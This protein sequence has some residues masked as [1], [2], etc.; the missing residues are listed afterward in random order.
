MDL[1]ISF[2]RKYRNTHINTIFQNDI[3]YCKWLYRQSFVK[4]QYPAIY[5]FLD[6]KF[7]KPEHDIQ[8]IFGKYK[9]K[10]LSDI[11]KAKDIKYL[12]Y[13]YNLSF[14]KNHIEFKKLYKAIDKIFKDIDLNDYL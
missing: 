12:L 13:L 14:V 3:E 2:G 6:N 10:Y 7:K 5:D 9:N 11:C 1:I 4:Y 8:I